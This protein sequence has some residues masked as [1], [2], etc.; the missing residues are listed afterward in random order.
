V[1]KRQ[2]GNTRY[3]VAC[4]LGGNPNCFSSRTSQIVRVQI[5]ASIGDRPLVEMTVSNARLTNENTGEYADLVVN[6]SPNPTTGLLNWR[7]QSKEATD[8][9]LLLMNTLGKEQLTQNFSSSSQIHEGTIDMSRFNSGAYI[10]KFKVG[11]KVIAK[12]I[13]KN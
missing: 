9:N 6:V 4:E 10:L 13:I 2:E 8:V 12:K 1:Y 5:T 3:Y 11:E 7:L